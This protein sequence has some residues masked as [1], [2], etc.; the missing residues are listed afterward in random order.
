MTGT[1]FAGAV[2]AY[3]TAPKTPARVVGTKKETHSTK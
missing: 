1:V 3:S 2:G